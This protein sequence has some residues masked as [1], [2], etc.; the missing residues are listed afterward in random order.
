MASRFAHGPACPATREGLAPLSPLAVAAL[1]AASLP[2]LAPGELSF[3]LPAHAARFVDPALFLTRVSSLLRASSLPLRV[4]ALDV[5]HP[6]KPFGVQLTRAVTAAEPLCEY[7]GELV[8]S[9]Q[10]RSRAFTDDGEV[11]GY[12]F[13]APVGGR[14]TITVDG[15]GGENSTPLLERRVSHSFLCLPEP[16]CVGAYINDVRTDTEAAFRQNL[17]ER[18]DSSPLLALAPAGCVSVLCGG[19]CT[20]SS[21]EQQPNVTHPHLIVY[22]EADAKSG[23]ELWLPYGRT[24]WRLK[25]LHTH[26]L[27]PVADADCGAAVY[28]GPAFSLSPETAH[29]VLT[30]LCAHIAAS[31]AD[32]MLPVAAVDLARSP[33]TH[34]LFVRIAGRAAAARAAARAATLCRSLS[35]AAFADHSGGAR[36]WVAAARAV[37]L[38]SRAHRMAVEGVEFEG[39]P[40]APRMRTKQTSCKSTGGAGPRTAEA[41]IREEAEE[42][43]D[44]DEA[45][46][47]A[48]VWIDVDDLPLWEVEEVGAADGPPCLHPPSAVS[49]GSLAPFTVVSWPAEQALMA[50]FA[51]TWPGWV[52]THASEG[53]WGRHTANASLFALRSLRPDFMACFAPA[54]DPL[55]GEM[56]RAHVL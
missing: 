19:G 31:A 37:N 4:R 39:P 22:A 29:G 7:G 54:L 3:A 40:G 6:A 15:A 47:R 32:D 36:S 20:S 28:H 41:E 30:A 44:S 11:N 35:A 2:R 26:T 56:E 34:S 45:D 14:D 38:V 24:Y 55:L 25:A 53:R 43:Y 27:P 5:D 51:V 12:M 18:P 50:E 21:G 48:E 52:W 8:V 10:L 13:S 23:A 9:S 42:E 49:L 17:Y 1:S 16:R 46:R 33:P